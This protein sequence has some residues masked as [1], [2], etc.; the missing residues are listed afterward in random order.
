MIRPRRARYRLVQNLTVKELALNP[1]K[2]TSAKRGARF[3]S[4]R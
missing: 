4:W 3:R 2:T 1:G